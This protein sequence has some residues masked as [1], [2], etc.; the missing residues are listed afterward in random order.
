VGYASRAESE[1]QAREDA[2]ALDA[3]LGD[4][5]MLHPYDIANDPDK[6]EELADLY[7]ELRDI[8]ARAHRFR[9]DEDYAV[10][11][12]NELGPQ[13]VRT[14]A[15]LTNT[16]GLAND[17]GHVDIESGSYDG[18]V[19]PLAIILGN[20]D[21]SGRMDPRVREALLDMDPSDEPPIEGTNASDV[22]DQ[23][24]Q[25]RYRTLA[26]LLNEGDFSPQTTA[27]MANAIIRDGPIG[28]G[29][30]DLTGFVHR[31]T[32]DDHRE[33]AS[34]EWA[35]LAALERD[36]AAANIFYRTDADEF[37]GEL[38]NLYLMDGDVGLRVAAER[39]GLSEDDLRD[40]VNQT[41]ANTL[42]GGILEHP[43]ATGTTYA[44]ETVELVEAMIDA[45]G[46]EYVDAPDS[47]RQALAHIST[48]YTVDLAIAAEGGHE[49]L[50][51]GRLP[52]LTEAQIDAFFQ[53][54]SEGEAARVVLGQNAAALV[55]DQIGIDAAAIAEGD[56]NAFGQGNAL[57]T[58]Y[59][60][61]LGEAWDEVQIGW[62]EQ[63][64]SLV[65]GWRSV[66]DPV[67]DLVSGK[68]VERIPVVNV[69]T[70][71]PLASNVVDGVTGQIKDGINSAIYDNL[72]PAPEIEA[73]TTW[74]DA[75]EPEVR[76]AVATGLYRDE[77]VRRTFLDEARTA[78]PELYA[79]VTAD[80]EITLGEFRE[81]RGV[82]NAV[83]NQSERIID[84]FE[85][86]MAFD[87][88]FGE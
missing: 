57:A 6:L 32:L 72:I 50:P 41:L 14:M 59:Y 20:A 86:D 81:L 71:L 55:T 19:V 74:R 76:T 22:Q 10:A 83:L 27:D 88:V 49:D 78:E 77:A 73:M 51:D 36:D 23:L 7:P 28:S 35:A 52:N 43:L 34:N 46:S 44:P 18:F 1:E 4:H 37:P 62:V 30:H 38:E 11:L 24:D 8:L 87:R 42:T 45:A 2:A 53:E 56:A 25:M 13:N 70:D 40:E 47:V 16:F 58:A 63:R 12:V 75:V 85:T 15:D 26:L 48:P 3:I 64:E 33:L 66:T 82:S 29:M 60:R 84:G 69:A 54:V 21:R 39:L 79:Q 65:A 9:D 17:M 68:I 61:E 31:D 67:V 5:G 80:G